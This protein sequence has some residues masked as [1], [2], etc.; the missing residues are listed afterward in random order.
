METDEPILV[1]DG[2]EQSLFDPALPDGGLPPAV[3]VKSYCVFRATRDVPALSDGVGYTYHHHVD[4]AVW[5][6]RLYVGWNSCERDEDVWPSRE[7]FST[8]DD[9]VAWTPPAELFPAGS[10]TA[11]RMYFYLAP[12]GRMLAIAGLRGDRQKVDE[13]LKGGL[14][15]REV[16]P[17]HTLAPPH[18][19]QPPPAGRPAG[20][21]PPYDASADAAF[22]DACRALLADNVYLEQQDR[23]RLLSP[24]R[25]MPWHD[26]ANWPGGKVPGDNEKWV[27]GKAFSFY[28]R[29]GD[30][31]LVAVSKMGWTTISFDDGRTWRQPAVPPTLVTGK[32]K[33][34]AQR[35]ADGR[36]ALVYNPAAR[37]RWPLVVV[38]GDDGRRFGGMSI[39]QGE[40]PIQRYAGADRSIGPQYVRGAGHWADDGSRPGDAAL[41][42]VYSMNKE[43]IWVSRVPLPVAADETDREIHD[44]PNLD[45]WNLYVPKWSSIQQ[46]AGGFSFDNRDPYDHPVATRAF[47]ESPRATIRC[48]VAP[49]PGRCGPLQVDV[50]TRFGSRPAVRVTFGEDGGIS[51]AT[52][53]GDRPLG[54][55]AAGRPTELAIEVDCSSGGAR[56]EV[57]GATTDLP[58]AQPADAVQRVSFRAGVYRGVGGKQP[59][60]PGSDRP[61]AEPAAWAVTGV[62]ITSGSGR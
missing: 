1:I 3:G 62:A 6:G 9:G 7:L 55:L 42:L 33:V 5:R 47:P 30:G 40:L 25:R 8:S 37:Q 21:P 35:T 4:M 45:R 57:D 36:F 58:L 27:A 17:D 44:E 19:L 54:M 22:V 46:V 61:A 60:A 43:D 59:V 29:A 13:Q 41:W 34:W 28:R 14:V 16:R 51:A 23:G 12:N 50:L 56:V 31:A 15:V 20:A 11:L 39:V 38:A 10:S 48:A 2:P 53:E 26:G 49:G 32:A 52:P 24:A 18:T